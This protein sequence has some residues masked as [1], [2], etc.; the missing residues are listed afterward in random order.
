MCYAMAKESIPFAKYPALLALEPHHGVDLGSAYSTP[1]AAKIF[2][3]Y[4]AASQCQAFVNTLSK[5]H[6]ASFLMDGITDAGNQEDE[7]VVLVHCSRDDTTQEI[8]PRTCY[9]PIHSPEQVVASGLLVCLGD[10]LKILGVD[11]VLDMDKVLGMEEK[12]GLVG[13]GTDGVA[14]NVG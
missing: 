9:L 4:I 6:F 11:N 12:P 3:G 8:T 1:D 10:A 5:S 2:T 13:G 7:L 14:V